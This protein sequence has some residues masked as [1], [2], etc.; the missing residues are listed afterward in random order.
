MIDTLQPRMDTDKHGYHLPD[1][2]LTHSIIGSAF[3]VLNE[4]GHGLNEKPYENALTV[5][6]GLQGIVFEQQRRFNVLY[7]QVPIGEFIPDLIVG[8][9]VVADTKTIEQITAIERGQ[10]LNYLRITQLKVG[11]IIN[12][13]RPKLEWERV[14]L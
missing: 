12:F 13:K 14:I 2:E 1:G 3:E 8:N 6:F 11:F 10:M 5:E 4:L 9:S 7:K